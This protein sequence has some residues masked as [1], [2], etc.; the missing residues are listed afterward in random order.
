MLLLIPE[1]CGDNV[2]L[3]IIRG[4]YLFDLSVIIKK[5][6]YL[7]SSAMVVQNIRT[8]LVFS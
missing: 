3:Y 7:L 6:H 5:N 2:P 1:E 4:I 8:T